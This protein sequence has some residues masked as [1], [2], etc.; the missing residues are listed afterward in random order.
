MDRLLTLLIF[1]LTALSRFAKPLSRWGL[2][3]YE[4]WQPGQPLKL[5][6]VGYN[7]ARNTG[8]DVRVAAITEQLYD[9]FGPEEIELTVMTLDEQAVAGYFDADVKLLP[10]SSLFPLDLYRACSAHHAALLCEGSTLKSTFA[11]ALTLFL[12]EA[13]GIMARQGKPC[14][15]YGSEVG[16]MA[17]FLRRSAARLCRE[18]YFMTRTR[19]SLARLE[20][21]GLRGSAGTDTAWCYHR[22]ICASGAEA[23]LRAQGWDGERPLLG[24]AVI[25][26]FC[27]PVRSSLWRWVR[28]HVTGDLSQQYDKWYFFSDSTRRRADYQRYI[29]EL[30]AG[31]E[32]SGSGCPLEGAECSE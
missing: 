6:L 30:A 22:A 28:G 7:G 27:W 10:F 1:L 3:V 29:R 13:A 11:N 21:L 9:L 26:P 5:L 12:C 8:S 16:E 15:G 31:A 24:V 19:A 18:T 4:Q 17:P 14:V 32:R 23:L 2:G 20:E 25:D